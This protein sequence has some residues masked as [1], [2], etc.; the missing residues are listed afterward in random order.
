MVIV[1]KSSGPCWPCHFIFLRYSPPPPVCFSSDPSTSFNLF[2]P[3]LFFC[4]S[5]LFGCSLLSLFYLSIYLSVCL[6]ALWP[7]FEGVSQLLSLFMAC[8][9][10]TLTL[11]FQLVYVYCSFVVCY[12]VCVFLAKKPGFLKK[13]TRIFFNNGYG[14][15]GRCF[16]V[17]VAI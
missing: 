10:F 13:I 12:F 2:C 11:C 14:T 16:T 1:I 6:A 15:V 17:Q 3:C 5:R 7:L 4:V 9:S 8:T